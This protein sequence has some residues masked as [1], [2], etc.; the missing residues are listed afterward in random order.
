M[1]LLGG[2][3]ARR[4]PGAELPQ[5]RGGNRCFT[6]AWTGNLG[7]RRWQSG[8]V[9]AAVVG[10]PSVFP[11]TGVRQICWIGNYTKGKIQTNK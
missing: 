5:I 2:S 10:G 1:M 7:R 9:A 6:L 4:T 11:V 3:R 8:G